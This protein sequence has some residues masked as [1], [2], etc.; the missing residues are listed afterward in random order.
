MHKYEL[1]ELVSNRCSILLLDHGCLCID[2]K[3][4]TQKCT[5]YIT[6]YDRQNSQNVSKV[7]VTIFEDIHQFLRLYL[8]K[9]EFA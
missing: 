5:M 4:N 6:C 7:L 9:S 1:F 3:L 2:R 8:E